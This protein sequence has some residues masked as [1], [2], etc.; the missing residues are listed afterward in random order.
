M[1]VAYPVKDVQHYRDLALDHRK[2]IIYLGAHAGLELLGLIQQTDL[3]PELFQCQ[4]LNA[5][6]HHL[7]M[8]ARCVRPF[9][10]ILTAR[11]PKREIALELKPSMPHGHGVPLGATHGCPL[12]SPCACTVLVPSSYVTTVD[13]CHD[14]RRK[15]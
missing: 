4:A 13:A 11:T 2:G 3:G 10:R 5:A 6:H 15:I 12:S 14:R 1:K 9:P 7:L 8:N